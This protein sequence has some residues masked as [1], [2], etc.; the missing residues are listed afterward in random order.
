ML[1]WHIGRDIFQPTSS[2]TIYKKRTSFHIKMFRLFRMLVIM[3]L[4]NFRYFVLLSNIYLFTTP[5]TTGSVIHSLNIISEIILFLLLSVC[6]V[7]VTFSNTSFL[8]KFSTYKVRKIYHIMLVFVWIFISL[9]VV[10]AE[11]FRTKE[12][13]RWN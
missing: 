8:L 5:P 7:N 13:R 11:T 12:K 10:W 4:Q 1:A 9:V 6:H 2:S 3:T